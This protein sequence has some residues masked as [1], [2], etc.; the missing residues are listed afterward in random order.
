MFEAGRPPVWPPLPT[1]L[2]TPMQTME[3]PALGSSLENCHICITSVIISIIIIF[4]FFSGITL[5]RRQW[6]IEKTD[7]QLSENLWIHV[8]LS[9]SVIIYHRH[10]HHHYHQSSQSIQYHHN[11]LR[12]Y[13]HITTIK[14]SHNFQ[15]WKEGSGRRRQQTWGGQAGGKGYEEEAMKEK[16][17]MEERELK[18]VKV[19]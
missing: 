14:E 15:I 6:I 5:L 4:I 17:V 13:R 16:V 3:Q 19:A 12:H 7:N 9:I 18:K 1:T 8:V 2:N 10:R 11:H